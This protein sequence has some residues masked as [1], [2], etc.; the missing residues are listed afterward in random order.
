[1]RLVPA[2]FAT[3]F[4]KSNKNDFNDADAIAEA[5]IRGHMRFSR[6]KSVEE[7]DMQALQ[8][9][10]DRMIRERTGQINQI[11]AFL[12]EN[13]VTIVQGRAN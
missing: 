9:A 8:R 5:A 3:P 4:C 10:R 2:Q 7:L 6:V 1:M 12:L 11:R 13:G